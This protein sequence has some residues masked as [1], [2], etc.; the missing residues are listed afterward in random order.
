MTARLAVALC[1]LPFVAAAS[2]CALFQL[3]GADCNGDKAYARGMNDAQSGH[4]MDEYVA[5]SCPAETKSVVNAAY[6][7]GYEHG[8]ASRPA[9]AAVVMVAGPTAYVPPPT[10]IEAYGKRAC[11]YDCKEAYGKLACGANPGDNCVEAYG[12]LR[13]GQACRESFGRIVCAGDPQ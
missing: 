6:R 9:P 13:C 5:D 2:G 8:I 7:D 4:R 12:N 10:C 3:Q 1:L 11:G